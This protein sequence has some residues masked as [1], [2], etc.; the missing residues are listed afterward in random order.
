MKIIHSHS[1]N[2]EL[3][4]VAILLIPFFAKIATIHNNHNGNELGNTS[5]YD[6]FYQSN[7][8]IEAYR[9]SVQIHSAVLEDKK[10][11]S[12]ILGIILKNATGSGSFSQ[13]QSQPLTPDLL[14]QIFS[15]YGER[16]LIEDDDLVDEMIRAAASYEGEGGGGYPVLNV[17][18]F[19]H[20]LTYDTKLYDVFNESRFQTHYEDV[21]G[22]VTYGKSDGSI[23]GSGNDNGSD[24]EAEGDKG[25]EDDSGPETVRY[26]LDNGKDGQGRVKRTFTF[27]HIDFL[28]DGFRSRTQYAF[29]WVAVIVCYIAWF[30]FSNSYD[31]HVCGGET[32][33]FEK[34]FGCQV[35]Q[36]IVLWI[37]VFLSMM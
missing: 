9:K 34:S 17:D 15:Y 28:A 16:S 22:L 2:I 35:A 31:I 32:E 18:T 19:L 11:I 37:L 23:S 27:P 25:F 7:F 14:R 4:V 10:I 36:S 1:L 29:V 24:N 26:D 5:N 12:D 6:S 33:D 8:E 20:A 13:S 3:K 21:F 30:P